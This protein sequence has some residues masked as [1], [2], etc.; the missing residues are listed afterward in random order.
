MVAILPLNYSRKVR[1]S[2]SLE[3]QIHYLVK[4]EKALDVPQ[5]NSLDYLRT[6]AHIIKSDVPTKLPRFPVQF[7]RLI[8]FELLD[9]ELSGIKQ[10]NLIYCN[11]KRMS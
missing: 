11:I 1:I 6:F 9:Y 8:Q 2:S 4:P 10:K 3:V 7:S 5:M